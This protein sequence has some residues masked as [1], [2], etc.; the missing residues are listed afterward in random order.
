MEQISECPVLATKEY[1][2]RHD[3]VLIYIHWKTCKHYDITVASRWYEDKPST[4]TEGKDLAIL[5][6]MPIDADKEITSSR[7]NIMID[8][9][10]PSECNV[11]NKETEKLSKYKDLEIEVNAAIHAV[12]SCTG[13]LLD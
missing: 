5:W 9:S 8:M 12:D 4:V 2:E 13:E 10:V 11:A 7:P 1:L 3:K 6:D